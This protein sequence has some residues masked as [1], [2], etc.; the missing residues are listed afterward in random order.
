MSS[1]SAM[2]L[3][4]PDSGDWQGIVFMADRNNEKPQRM[5]GSGFRVHEHFGCHVLGQRA[6]A[7]HGEHVDRKLLLHDR[8]LQ[9]QV[10]GSSLIIVNYDPNTIPAFLVASSQPGGLVD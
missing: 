3:T 10:E 8:R 6:A 9:R 4:A 7:A 1:G 2:Y 5:T